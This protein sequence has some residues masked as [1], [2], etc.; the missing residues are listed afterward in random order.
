MKFFPVLL[1]LSLAAHASS[2]DPGKAAVDFLEKVRQRKLNLEPG[3]DTALSPQTVEGKR[4]EIA[5]QLERIAHD[6]GSDALEIGEVKTDENFA[7]VLVRK[8]GGFDPAR[9]R[10]FPVAL[11]KQPG[12]EWSA[13]PVPASF[14][15]SGAGYIGG[16]RQRLEAL[17]DWML[18]EQVVDLETLRAQSTERMR[19]KIEA[20]LSAAQLRGYHAGDLGAQFLAACGRYDLPAVL[21]FLGGLSP[22][23]PDDWAQRLKAAD[24]AMAA[25]KDAPRPWR[26]L[27]S[28]EVAK[29]VVHHEE[30]DDSGLVS[31]AFLDPRIV[32]NNGGHIELVHFD[33]SK[34]PNGLWR[35]NPPAAFLDKQDAADGEPSDD[36]GESDPE[37]GEPFP[38]IWAQLHPTQPQPTAELAGEALA[39]ALH[40]G[41]LAALLKISRLDGDPVRAVKA[42]TQAAAVWWSLHDGA[43]VSY[44]VPLAFKSD[45]TAAV[46]LMQFFS[47][48][49]PERLNLRSFHFEKTAAGWLW[50]SPPAADANKELR[51]WASAEAER[52]PGQWQAKLLESVPVVADFTQLEAPTEEAARAC[53]EKWLEAAGHG[54]VETA[55]SLFARLGDPKGGLSAFQNLGY[56]I[57]GSRVWDGPPQVIGVQRGKI[58]TAVGVKISQQGGK[59]MLPLY[60]V[61]QTAQGPR[62]LAEIDLFAPEN[63][64]RD[65]LNNEAL[66]K[67]KEFGSEAATNELKSLLEEHK[68]ALPKK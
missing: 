31:F 4:R 43:S 27:L 19:Q 65:F 39:R 62:I 22:E 40:G 37:L 68:K 38:A 45:E 34:S 46:A 9:L 3:G 17:E 61:V 67:L 54:D 44:A 63:R 5:K 2:G 47:A 35:M 55:L 66:A 1:A 33:L 16:L 59:S 15:N 50:T 42:C 64:G 18:R 25:G 57:N 7:A 52:W 51:A 23:L 58:L 28:P 20:N 8:V 60:P 29:V 11:V 26:L 56:E 30:E 6:L 10:V 14:E 36:A 48:R 49:D 24:A 13:A 32:G 53:V 12:G 21:G 41:D